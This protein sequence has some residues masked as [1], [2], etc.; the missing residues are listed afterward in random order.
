LESGEGELEG[1]EAIGE[2]VEAV[3][4]RGREEGGGG[5]AGER[6]ETAKAG[7]ADPASIRPARREGEGEEDI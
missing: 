1:W 6:E 7:S 5:E 4:G 3:N 2:V